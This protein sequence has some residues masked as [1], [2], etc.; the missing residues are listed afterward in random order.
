[1]GGGREKRHGCGSG[2]GP[3]TVPGGPSVC[4]R[5]ALA[6]T[7]WGAQKQRG[8]GARMGPSSMLA[9]GMLSQ[10]SP[11]G[12]KAR[13]VHSVAKDAGGSTRDV[14]SPFPKRVFSRKAK[15]GNTQL[16]KKSAKHSSS[17]EY[18]IW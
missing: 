15:A 7:W 12:S 4:G 2:V 1:M 6:D 3:S 5:G 18:S 17:T 13:P 14:V 8:G 11:P 16:A 9:G 10:V